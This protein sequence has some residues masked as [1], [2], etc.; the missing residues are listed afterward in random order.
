M[1][2]PG[3]AERAAFVGRFVHQNYHGGG[4]AEVRE[5]MRQG[6]EEYRTRGNPDVGATREPFAGFAETIEEAAEEPPASMVASGEMS[7]TRERVPQ[8]RENPFGEDVVASTL[9]TLLGFGLLI[10]ALYFASCPRPPK[11]GGW[12]QSETPTWG[13][14]N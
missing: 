7:G 10:G 8:T 4:R 14:Q 1:L 11:P 6:Q 9:G 3:M 12:G 5:L 13:G 2:R